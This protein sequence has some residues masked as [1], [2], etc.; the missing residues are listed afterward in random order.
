MRP[1]PERHGADRVGHVILVVT[2]LAGALSAYPAAIAT[3]GGFII[4]Q[5]IEWLHVGGLI[6]PLLSVIDIVVIYLTLREWRARAGIPP[7]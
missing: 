7:R 1:E 6:R 3:L 5:T 2:L 4:Y